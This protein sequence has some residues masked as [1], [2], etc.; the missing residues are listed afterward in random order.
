MV[1][2]AGRVVEE[3]AAVVETEMDVEVEAVVNAGTGAEADAG[4]ATVGVGMVVCWLHVFR[5]VYV[6]SYM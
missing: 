1:V 6:C 5:V 4:T 2:K 3:E